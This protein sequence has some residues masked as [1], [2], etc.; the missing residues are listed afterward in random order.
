MAHTKDLYSIDRGDDA[1]HES[2][3]SRPIG[4]V[5]TSVEFL[6]QPHSDR[7][8][9]RTRPKIPK[10]CDHLSENA[11]SARKITILDCSGQVSLPVSGLVESDGSQFVSEESPVC[12]PANASP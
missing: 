12:G 7:R 11:P 10:T 4:L 9:L 5:I 6:E 8:A 3:I 2:A 1:N